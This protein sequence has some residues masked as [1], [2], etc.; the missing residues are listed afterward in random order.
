MTPNGYVVLE[1]LNANVPEA[2]AEDIAARKAEL[3]RIFGRIDQK[4]YMDA[5][6]VKLE[7]K[8]NNPD[9]LPPAK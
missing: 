3:A 1:V 6:E 2:G 9:Y 4:A 8:V 5:L 7:A